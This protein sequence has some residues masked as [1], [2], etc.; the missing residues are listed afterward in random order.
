MK[1]RLVLKT[2]TKKNKEV[3]MKFNI[4][5]SKHLGFINF[6]NLALNQDQPVILSFEKVSKSGE[7]EESKIVGEFK[8]TGK[9]DVGLMQL[10]EEVQ[11]AEQR[12]KKQQQRRKHK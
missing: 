2:R 3:C 9:D 8:F 6:V 4:A 5:P 12:K 1:L 11:E 7:K 10:E